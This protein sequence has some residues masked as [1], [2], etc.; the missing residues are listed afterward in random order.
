MARVRPQMPLQ[1]P[2]PGE[3]LPTYVTLVIQVVGEDVHRESRHGNIHLSADVALFG[4]SRIQAPVG[5]LVSGQVGTGGVVLSTFAALVL[6]PGAVPAAT[7]PV[8]VLLCPP[9]S[10]G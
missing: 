4:I 3:G 2:W 1:Q 10:Y 6:K 5:L 8:F 7:A 9:I